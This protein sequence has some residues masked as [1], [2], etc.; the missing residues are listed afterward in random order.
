MKRFLFLLVLCS[1]FLAAAGTVKADENEPF[2][3]PWADGVPYPTVSEIV[4]PHGTQHVIVQ[5]C[6]TD[7]EYGFLHETSI[8]QL[9]GELIVGW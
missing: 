2:L 3:K 6:D 4:F 9:D 8:G 1:L 7:P 5:D